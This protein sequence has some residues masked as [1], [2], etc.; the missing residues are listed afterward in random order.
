MNTNQDLLQNPNSSYTNGKRLVINVD[1]AKI[2][3]EAKYSIINL[4][5]KSFYWFF[6]KNLIII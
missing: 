6:T 4:T 1:A 2:F 5:E 3:A